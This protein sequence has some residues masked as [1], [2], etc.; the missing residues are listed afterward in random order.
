MSRPKKPRRK[1]SDLPRAL[2]RTE[3]SDDG[4]TMAPEYP[5]LE[6]REPL[7]E[8]ITGRASG[9]RDDL[10]SLFDSTDRD[11]LADGFR[12]GSEDDDDS[13]DSPT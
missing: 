8:E 4:T 7:P 1:F 11:H 13:K 9:T 12:G 2:R 5:A 10:V 3:P 6:G